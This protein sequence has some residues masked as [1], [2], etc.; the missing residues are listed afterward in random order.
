MCKLCDLFGGPHEDHLETA[1]TDARRADLE[2]AYRR[3]RSE[4]SFTE[5]EESTAKLA[6]PVIEVT[7]G[8]VV[9]GATASYAITDEEAVPQA[10]L[11]ALSD[12][13]A[14]ARPG[15]TVRLRVVDRD[16][17]REGMWS[18][19]KAEDRDADRKWDLQRKI[20]RDL[21]WTEGEDD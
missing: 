12:G 9:S 3:L 4:L 20:R 1:V 11:D 7:D 17:G 19:V 18:V 13:L 10:V 6:K 8:V 15:Q 16:T 5:S 2:A 14:F 21:G